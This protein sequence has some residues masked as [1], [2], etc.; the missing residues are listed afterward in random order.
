MKQLKLIA[1][2]LLAIIALGALAA[3]AAQAEE[4]PFW[5]VAGSRLKASQT[6]NITAKAFSANLTFSTPEAGIT[7]TCK[8]LKLNV[9]VIL[10]SEKGES[11]KNNGVIEFNECSV[12]GNGAACTLPNPII[13]E[14]LSSELV[15]NV[16]SKKVGK[17]LLEE[18]FPTSGS[19]IFTIKFV[20][21]CT[22]KETKLTGKFAAEALTEAEGVIELGQAAKQ[23]KS[24]LLKFPSTSVSEVWLIKG[25]VGSAVKVGLDAFG[26]EEFLIGTTLVLLE[27][28][29]EWSPLP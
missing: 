23:A 15:E 26:D 12:S 1:T 27:G 17:K 19:D 24:W 4:A 28:E 25:G 29:G 6:R 18:F 9:G 5:T 13:T 8:K 7:L 22:S 3:T 16:E 10:G 14:P 20:G 21:T 11:G 2:T